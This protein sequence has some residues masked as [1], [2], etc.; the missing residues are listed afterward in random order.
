MLLSRSYEVCPCDSVVS[1]KFSTKG[2]GK[3]GRSFTQR[4]Q[5]SY[6]GVCAVARKRTAWKLSLSF[7]LVSSYV[8][9][10]SYMFLGL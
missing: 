4:G 2:K 1:P 6:L 9:K 3:E 8:P 10:V 7:F 5:M